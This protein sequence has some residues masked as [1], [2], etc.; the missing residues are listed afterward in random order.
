[1][2]SSVHLPRASQLLHVAWVPRLSP[3]SASP[4]YHECSYPLQ[5]T[6]LHFSVASH[7]H[8]ESVS[9]Q[10]YESARLTDPAHP[11]RPIYLLDAVGHV[12][13][14]AWAPFVDTDW[15][16]VACT[17]TRGK[18]DDEGMLQFW[19][20]TNDVNMAFTIKLDDTPLRVGWRPGVPAPSTLGT[21]AVSMKK[22]HVLVLDIPCT[23]AKCIQ[24][25]PRMILP[26]SYTHLT[27]P[28]KA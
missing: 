5:A 2:I 18:G 12:Y 24:L 23:E 13:D 15:L 26:V 28:T 1:M 7:E 8:E 17:K 9:I 25:T 22:G 19:K 21:L 6:P 3:W 11:S 20:H 27:L 16:V 14:L 10:P 4:G